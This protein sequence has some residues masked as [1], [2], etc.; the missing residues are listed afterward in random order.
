MKSIEIKGKC[1]S[2]DCWNPA[3]KPWGLAPWFS[4]AFCED[5]VSLLDL[6]G[7]TVR[8]ARAGEGKVFV[9]HV[10]DGVTT[11]GVEI[12]SSNTDSETLVSNL[13][14]KVPENGAAAWETFVKFK[15]EVEAEISAKA[16]MPDARTPVIEISD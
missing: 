14:A 6:L 12:V 13:Y 3:P 9:W 10:L 7:A 1:L 4:P 5:N 8:E 15:L 2:G 11:L 16:T